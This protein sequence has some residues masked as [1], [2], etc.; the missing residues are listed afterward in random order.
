ML[1]V[2]FDSSHYH[3]HK[4]IYTCHFNRSMKLLHT[5][6]DDNAEEC[7]FRTV[8]VAE[9]IKSKT[10]PYVKTRE[11]MTRFLIFVTFLIKSDT[12]SNMAVNNGLG[13]GT[14]CD[15]I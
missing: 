10:L 12:S 1:K 11:E 15:I 13:K 7:L 3:S 4:L 2:L 6:R 5:I 14:L 9:K 8:R